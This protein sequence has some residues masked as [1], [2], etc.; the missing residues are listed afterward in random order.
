[1]L[2]K[3]APLDAF[4]ILMRANRAFC[5]M[6]NND[7]VTP[8]S[9]Y[10]FPFSRYIANRKADESYVDSSSSR[11]EISR[12]MIDRR[13]AWFRDWVCIEDSLSLSLCFLRPSGQRWIAAKAGINFYL[14]AVTHGA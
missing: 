13:R 7:D 14:D 6:T 8:T 9:V 1:L 12:A 5:N 3:A 10:L 11:T 2:T 4:A